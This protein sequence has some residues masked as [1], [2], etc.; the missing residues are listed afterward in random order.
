ML[1]LLLLIWHKNL[2]CEFPFLPQTISVLDSCVSN[3]SAIFLRNECSVVLFCTVATSNHLNRIT[4]LFPILSRL[5]FTERERESLC[6]FHL[7]SDIVPLHLFSFHILL[8]LLIFGTLSH[9]H[10]LISLELSVLKE[11]Q[12]QDLLVSPQSGASLPLLSLLNRQSPKQ[13]RPID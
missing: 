11:A 13:G 2:I 4:E 12:E 8:L 1:L 7:D 9:S 5:L 10:H 3:Y 6:H